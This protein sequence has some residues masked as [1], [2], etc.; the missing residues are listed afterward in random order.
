MLVHSA[1]GPANGGLLEITPEMWHSAFDI[2]VHAIFYLCRAAIPHMRSRQGG[3]ILLISSTAG[4]LATPSHI[5]YQAVKGA[6]PHIARGLA[7]EFASDNIRVNCIAPGVIRT[8]FHQ[9]MTPEQKTLNL[10]HRIPLKR[11]GTPE[12]VADLMLAVIKNEYIT[13]DTLTIDGGLS[14]RI[15]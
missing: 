7:R 5:A 2:H 10:D 4:K 8:R 14:M 12:Q 6:L 3:S 15:A 1:G 9:H 13:G 11:E